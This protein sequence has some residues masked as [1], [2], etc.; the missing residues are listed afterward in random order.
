MLFQSL[1]SVWGALALWF[2]SPS[3]PGLLSAAFISLHGAI[4][5]LIPGFP[6]RKGLLLLLLPSAVLAWWLTLQPSNNRPWAPDVER[7]PRAVLDGDQVTIENV[8]SFS[9]LSEQSVTPSWR[10]RSFRLSQVEA[11]D[12]YLSDWGA[13]GIV[14][15]IVSFRIAGEQPLAISIEAR[16][17]ETE[18]YSAIR[19]FFRQYELYYVVADESDVIGVRA[20]HR[21]ET[22]T[23]LQMR[24]E[25]ET[26]RLLLHSYLER[27]NHLNSHPEWYNAFT[28]NC[29]NTIRHHA[30]EIG[31]ERPTDYRLFVNKRLPSLFYERGQINTALPLEQLVSQSDI[32]EIAKAASDESFS[33]AIRA[34]LPPR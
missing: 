26:A 5:G 17:E 16:K 29:T 10:V 8:R 6:L 20:K 34:S 12:F 23:L 13:A 1:F 14:H 19:G 4:L 25:P 30:Q 22:L 24:A 32:T 31:A 3:L 28:T 27:I 33:T 11:I 2:D 21:N 18:S 9:Y 7:L 15:T